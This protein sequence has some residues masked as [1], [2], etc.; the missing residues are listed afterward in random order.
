M[1]ETQSKRLK[2]KS[3]V[4]KIIRLID[5]QGCAM[6]EPKVLNDLAWKLVIEIN[7]NWE[8]KASIENMNRYFKKFW[9]SLLKPLFNVVKFN[10]K[11]F[12]RNVFHLIC[13]VF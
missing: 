2:V 13:V 5:V 6:W 3:S 4:R 1:V 12:L 8:L 11:I 10:N 9:I 7:R